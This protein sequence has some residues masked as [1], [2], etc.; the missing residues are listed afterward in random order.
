[1]GY[2]QCSERE[3]CRRRRLAA[4]RG[5]SPACLNL[6]MSGLCFSSFGYECYLFLVFCVCVQFVKSFRCIILLFASQ[7]AKWV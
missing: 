2:C 6:S 5:V 4:S 3:R 7:H 1:M